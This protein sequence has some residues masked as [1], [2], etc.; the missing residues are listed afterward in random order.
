MTY[1]IFSESA[2]QN[3]V[4]ER[5]CNVPSISNASFGHERSGSLK[6]NLVF[7]K[8]VENYFFSKTI[9]FLSLTANVSF[10]QSLGHFKIVKKRITILKNVSKDS[11]GLF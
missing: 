9:K 8:V 3:L 11:I 10:T 7:L 5:Y 4:N 6:F 1:Y 2:G